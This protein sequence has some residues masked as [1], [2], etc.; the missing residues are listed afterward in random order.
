MGYVHHY[1][2][3]VGVV[4]VSLNCSEASIQLIFTSIITFDLNGKES[5]ELL[6]PFVNML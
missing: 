2:E 5:L 4:I 3:S 1:L 6:A